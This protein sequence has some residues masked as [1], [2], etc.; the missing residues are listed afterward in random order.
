MT[1]TNPGAVVKCADMLTSGRR[2]GQCCGRP[3]K[4]QTPAGKPLCGGH[5]RS[6]DQ[7]VPDRL[8]IP[9]DGGR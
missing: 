8:A 2:F 5:R 9:I 4:W 6:W 3:A 1:T 7:W